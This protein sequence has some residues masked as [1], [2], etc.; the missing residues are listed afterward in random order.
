M[1]WGTDPW[2]QGPWGGAIPGG[3]LPPSIVEVSPTI[4]EV[5]GGTI[6][7]IV[8]SNFFP[9]FIP[10]VML[11]PTGGPYTQIAKGYLWDPDFDLTP[12]R[13]FAGMPALQA[14]VYSLQVETPA[15]LSNVLE[16]VLEYKPFSNE[17]ITQKERTA[18]SS[19]WKTGEKIGA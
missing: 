5:E 18:W 8:G 1:G 2:G 11:G 7:T 17:V 15:G 19:K 4:L 12:S 6:L 13:A 9:E 10:Y 16:D 3:S 14:G